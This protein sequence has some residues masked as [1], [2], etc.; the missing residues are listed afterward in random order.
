ME[1]IEVRSPR[2]KRLFL[3]LPV[4][5]Y[6]NDPHWIRP[7]DQDI[8]QVFDPKRNKHFRHGEAVRWLLRRE[9]K[10]IGRVAAFVHKRSAEAV[11]G[12]GFFECVNDERAAFQLFDACRD[13]L[14][15]RGMEAMEGPVN[16]GEK[17]RWW[18]LLV[19]GFFKPVY[20]MNYHLPYYRDFFE[21]YG[22]R[23]YYEQYYYLYKL[24][25]QMPEK[26]LR[27]SER[28]ARD[29]NYSARHIDKKQL[30][31]YAEDFRL[32]YN[33]AWA[34]HAGFRPMGKPQA[35]QLISL[36]KPIMDENIIWFAYY[37]GEPIAFFIMLPEVNQIF[38]RINNGK[39]GLVEKL[40]F[41]WLRRRGA[42]RKMFGLVFGVAPEFQ[43]KGV[44]GYIIT[45][46]AKHIQPMNRYDELEMT[47]I[48]DFN[49]RMIHLVESLGT[50]KVRT[51]ITYRKLFDES[52][53][54]ERAPV[55]R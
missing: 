42:C 15:Q 41:A 37:R 48:G 3:E 50:E 54:F 12:M 18:G 46:A 14:A 24:S 10:V 44:E 34:G 1:L 4:S 40:R 53:P 43:G 47:W 11:G 28:I 49:P 45:A 13:W 31:K 8:G 2:E 6:R 35:L 21:R 51:A 55:I 22:F 25:R 9:G 30:E 16:F 38:G 20:G 33:K 17:D 19:D 27:R 52:K 32:V 36:V 26:Y 7:L 39:S 5:L 23:T 29:P